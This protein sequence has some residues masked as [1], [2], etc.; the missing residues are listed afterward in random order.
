M[1]EYTKYLMSLGFPEDYTPYL[2]KLHSMHPNWTFKPV[3]TN[4]YWDTVVT[5]EDDNVALIN[6]AND[7]YRVDNIGLDGANWYR[8][9][10][11][12]VAFYLDPRNFLTEK[13]VFMFESLK[14][15][16]GSGKESI[17]K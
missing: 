4:Y 2:N 15:N 1:N 3:K 17:T 7:L 12:V 11:E 8:A 6:Y 10:K 16:Y 5:K 14:Y 9:K 13:F